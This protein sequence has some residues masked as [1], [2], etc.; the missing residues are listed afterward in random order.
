MSC[1]ISTREGPLIYGP[2][3]TLPA[4]RWSVTLLAADG[5]S[6]ADKNIIVDMV[7][8]LGR[9]ILRSPA[10]IGIDASFEINL[11]QDV[12]D[13]EVRM[14]ASGHDYAVGFIIVRAITTDGKAVA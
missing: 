2:Y 9:R 7:Y 8:E 4:G 11:G 1:G 13:A 10:P 5:H 14:F 3:A 12:N 6:L